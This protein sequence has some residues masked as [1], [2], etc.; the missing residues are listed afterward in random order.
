MT[1]VI[2]AW[3]DKPQPELQLVERVS[4]AVVASWKGRRLKELFDSGLVSY[5][6]LRTVLPER[7]KLVEKA[8]ILQMTCEELCGR[9]V[10]N[11]R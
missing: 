5:E 2:N 1:Y 8:L 3:L 10:Y 4:G 6:E 9:C 11:G 7:L